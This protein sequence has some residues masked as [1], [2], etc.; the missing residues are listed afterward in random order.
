MTLPIIDHLGIIW[1]DA[2]I[3]QGVIDQVGIVILGE[4]IVLA[5]KDALDGIDQKALMRQGYLSGSIVCIITRLVRY[6]L[7]E[8][9]DDSKGHVGILECCTVREGCLVKQLLLSNA[10]A[11]L[12]DED[13]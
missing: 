12:F 6:L 13:W 7:D 5:G 10:I 9:L 8:L 11:C 1:I 2:T 4:E 3:A